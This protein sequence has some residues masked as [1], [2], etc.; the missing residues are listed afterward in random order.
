[1]EGMH[2]VEGGRQPFNRWPF[3][4]MPSEVEQPDGNPG[5]HVMRPGH[6]R[7]HQAVLPRARK[8]GKRVAAIEPCGQRRGETVDVL[9]DAGPLPE[10]RSVVDQDVHVGR[11]VTHRKCGKSLAFNTLTPFF[12]LCYL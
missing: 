7:A 12:W 2:D 4:P 5:V 11:I 10:S 8:H 6:A 1:M 9:P 3:K